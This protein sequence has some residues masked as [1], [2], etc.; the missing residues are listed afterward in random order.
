[1]DPTVQIHSAA[2][3]KEFQFSME[4]FKFIG[5]NDQVSSGLEL[6]LFIKKG[7]CT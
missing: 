5:L 6:L 2:D 7:Q 3:Q 4:A 1:M